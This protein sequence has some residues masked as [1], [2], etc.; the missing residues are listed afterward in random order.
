MG[1]IGLEA[2]CDSQVVEAE[3]TAAGKGHVDLIVHCEETVEL[4]Q[5][6]G[7]GSLRRGLGHWCRWHGGLQLTGLSGFSSYFVDPCTQAAHI[8]LITHGRPDNG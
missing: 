3:K 8:S 2:G 5:E 7:Y 6:E 4:L 1:G